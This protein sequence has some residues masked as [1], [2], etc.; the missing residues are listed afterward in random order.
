L[1]TYSDLI[2]FFAY[3]ALSHPDPAVY[4]KLACWMREE[5]GITHQTVDLRPVPRPGVTGGGV[6]GRNA[7]RGNPDQEW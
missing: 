7:Q 6:T 2:L 1:T 5:I 4:L 3:S